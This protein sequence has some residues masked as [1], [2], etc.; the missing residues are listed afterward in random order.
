VATPTGRDA[1]RDDDG[2][3]PVH[4]RGDRPGSRAT[5]GPMGALV[6]RDHRDREARAV[7]HLSARIL[8][9]A[10]VCAAASA[11]F[12]VLT[13]HDSG[14]FGAGNLAISRSWESD[15]SGSRWRICRALLSRTESQGLDNRLIAGGPAIDMA[16][17]VP[18]RPRLGGLLSGQPGCSGRSRTGTSRVG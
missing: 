5:N 10:A 13:E 14:H 7:A 8:L 12:T 17:R 3:D 4:G 16:S 11:R 18:R 9:A 6:H 15:T 1:N 2:R